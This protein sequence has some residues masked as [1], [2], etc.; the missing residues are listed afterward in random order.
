M[1]T[2]MVRQLDCQRYHMMS[3]TKSGGFVL[4]RRVPGKV[5]DIVS[6]STIFIS[7]DLYGWG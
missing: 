2:V 7:Y 5:P 3:K 4:D 1:N 6:L